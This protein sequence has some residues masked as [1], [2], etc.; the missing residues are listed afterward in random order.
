MSRRIWVAL[1][2]LLGLAGSLLLA[3]RPRPALSGRVE[4]DA[5]PAAGARVRL[6]GSPSSVLTAADGRFTL[7]SQ[8]M[9][10]ER[11]TAWKEGYLIAGVPAESK[12]LRLRLRP[13]PAEDFEGYQWVAPHADPAH[14]QNCGNCHAELVREWSASAH[15]RS[16]T[17][18]HFL[19]LYDGSDTKGRPHRDWNLLAEHPDGAGVCTACHAPAVHT[20]DPAYFDLR[21]AAGVARAGVHCDYCHKITG[22]TGRTGLTHGRFGLTLLRPAHGQLFFGPLDDVDRG[23]DSYSPLYRRS[24]YCASCHEAIVFGVHV[25][26]TYSEWRDS[27]ASREGKQC[28]TCHMA[29]T[30]TLTNLAPGKGGI[31]RDPRTLGN[32][33]FFT[34]SQEEM[35]RHC[36][37]VTVELSSQTEG[38]RAEVA[39]GAEDVGHQVPTGFIDRHLLLVVQ[40]LTADGQPLPL[41]A[42]PVLPAR[43]GATLAGEPGKL[44]AKLLHDFDGRGPVPFW[45]ADP[46]FADTRL[47]PGQTERLRFDFAPGCRQVRV[48]LLYRRF[49]QEVADAKGWPDNEIVVLDRVWAFP[50]SKRDSS[51]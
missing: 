9:P 41:R 21:Q 2:L 32:H 11:V 47:R 18:R 14:E 50:D 44:Y 31:E 51:Q 20:D 29:P 37:R 43:A 3:V 15:A 27:P 4:D 24:R 38:T 10:P 40:G 22:T 48:R 30:G 5:G 42:G 6:K 28:Q 23:E 35:L 19:G 13:L 12:P 17:G 33:R 34:G 1:F 49:W 26:S 25:Y 7:P 8:F 16:L 39:V 45:R 46:D 36:L